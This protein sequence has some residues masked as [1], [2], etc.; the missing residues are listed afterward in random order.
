MTR[1]QIENK[2]SNQTEKNEL[3]IHNVNRERES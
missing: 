1:G 3:K 2:K